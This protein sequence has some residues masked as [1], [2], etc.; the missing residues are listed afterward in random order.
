MK[1]SE[2]ENWIINL[3]DVSS[4]LDASTVEFV[5]KKHGVDDIYSIP[6]TCFSEVFD[7]LY[8][9]LINAYEDNE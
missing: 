1:R 3:E 6:T 9:Y 8:Q 4:Q 5:C 2:R 7:E